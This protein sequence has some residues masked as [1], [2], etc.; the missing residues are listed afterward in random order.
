MPF[1]EGFSSDNEEDFRVQ[2]DLLNSVEAEQGNLAAGPGSH[3][4]PSGSTVVHIDDQVG[5]EG[6]MSPGPVADMGDDAPPSAARRRGRP[7]SSASATPAKT[8]TAGTPRSSKGAA[9]VP[10]SSGRKRKAAEVESEA[11]PEP[12]PAAKRGRPARTT[13]VAASARLAAKSA[14]KSTRGRPK[15][16]ACGA[17]SQ[18]ESRHTQ[19]RRRRPVR[20]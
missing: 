15:A 2:S 20:G 12:T 7:T 9:V 18:R 8:P 19:E 6:D 1:L 17:R 11:E 4:G 16:S 13:G 5:E 14:K 3:T 10:K